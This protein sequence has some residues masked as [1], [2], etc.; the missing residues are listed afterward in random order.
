MYLYNAMGINMIRLMQITD[1]PRVAEIHVFGWRSAY[2][3]IVSDEFLFNKMIVSQRMISFEN[4][5]NNH[6]E[7][8]YVFDDGIIKA[9]LTIG[10]CRDTDKMN[11]F[12]L[13][14]IYVEP[15]MKR[16]GIG[17]KMVN[18]CEKK[19]IER[20]FNEV[21]LWVLEKN[22][23]ARLFYEKLGYYP[24]GTQKFID[25]LAASEIRYSKEL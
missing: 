8:N 1:V 15:F 10:A 25:F 4:A 3:G 20:G 19:A 22:V 5:V 7:E 13:W 23:N 6:T 12:E 21:C 17:N 14:G 18:H 11:S 24:D 9:I 16:Q 2:R